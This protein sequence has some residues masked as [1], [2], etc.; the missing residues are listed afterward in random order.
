[1][2][3]KEFKKGD[4]VEIAKIGGTGSL[5]TRL[6]NMGAVP[7]TKVRIERAAPLGDP[8]EISIKGYHLS[9]RKTEAEQIIVKEV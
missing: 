6:L 9:L 3:L 8:I 7:G 1:M 2:T 5:K 4:E